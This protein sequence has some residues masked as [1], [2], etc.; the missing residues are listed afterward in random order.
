MP[1]ISV[2]Q[3]MLILLKKY[4]NNPEKYDQIKKLYLLGVN[5]PADKKAIDALMQDSL[6][7][8]AEWKDFKIEASPA[9]IDADA[10]RRYFE[11]HLAFESLKQNIKFLNRESLEQY[12]NKLYSQLPEQARLDLKDEEVWPDEVAD[13]LSKINKHPHF[14][15][16]SEDDKTKLK[17][18]MKCGALPSIIGERY[19]KGGVLPL[20]LL[21]AT[22]EYYSSERGRITKEEKDRTSNTDKFG[23]LKYY[24]PISRMDLGYANQG[25]SYYRPSEASTFQE[26]KKW[27]NKLFEGLVHP[28][29]N[30]ISG[31]MLLQLKTLLWNYKQKSPQFED[32]DSLDNFIQCFA[33]TYLY[34][35]G[36]HSFFEFYYPLYIKEV[37]E[38]FSKKIP[39]FKSIGMYS[40]YDACDKAL[41][42][43]I[44]YNDHIIHRKM[45]H[46]ELREGKRDLKHVE[47]VVRQFRISK[48]EWKEEQKKKIK[49]QKKEQKNTDEEKIM[50]FHKDKLMK[51]LTDQV[52][53]KLFVVV[54]KTEKRWKKVVDKIKEEFSNSRLGHD[55]P[56]HVLIHLIEGQIKLLSRL[57]DEDGSWDGVYRK[58]CELKNKVEKNKNKQV[59]KFK[60]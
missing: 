18:L 50:R 24:M 30:A 16:F 20:P 10:T 45:I 22:H 51:M 60:K 3:A 35:S 1:V 19:F 38:E 42:D 21:Y 5:N 56:H 7:K 53:F 11:T 54:S 4:K 44:K 55:S 33:S 57:K 34:M 26:G 49:D 12:Y 48:E 17:L 9:I 40:L 58:L 27:P 32:K 41:E 59:A 28:F 43:T 14:S 2:G 37:A 25:F 36:G 31:T 46:Q 29:Q 6:F 47:P 52:A 23:I 13:A 15:Q 8:E 39:D